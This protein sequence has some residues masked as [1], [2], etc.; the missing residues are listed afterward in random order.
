MTDLITPPEHP[1]VA[2][3][4]ACPVITDRRPEQCDGD[5][6]GCVLE[7]TGNDVTGFC[8]EHWQE[9]ASREVSWIHTASWRPPA[10]PS[11]KEQALEQLKCVDA[12]LR[13]Q[14]IINTDKIR[15]ALEA[16]PND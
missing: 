12:D 16:L 6:I 4:A 11:L 8:A 14:G 15:L 7:W 10:P 9:V 13:K 5:A 3:W 1:S 2:W